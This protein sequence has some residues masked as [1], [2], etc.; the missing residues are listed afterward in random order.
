MALFG[1]KKKTDKKEASVEK[2]LAV[3]AGS[4]PSV[5]I[6]GENKEL[7]FLL[8]PRITEKTHS[9]ADRSNVYVFDVSS[10]ANKKII[11][12]AIFALYKLKPEKV[13]ILKVYRKPRFVKGH[14]GFTKIGRKAYVYLK[15]GEK[16]ELS[17]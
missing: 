7:D 3:S 13:A 10:K 8:R 2:T 11:S 5:S 14:K 16:L 6:S 4:G 1:L 17:K 15:K 12:E 9:L